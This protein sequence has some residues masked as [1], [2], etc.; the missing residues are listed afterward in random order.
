MM[1]NLIS[2]HDYYDNDK[3]IDNIM[4]CSDVKMIITE[5]KKMRLKFGKENGGKMTGARKVLATEIGGRLQ[6][7]AC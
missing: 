3:I 7:C 6:G 5:V 4:I 1:I 2:D